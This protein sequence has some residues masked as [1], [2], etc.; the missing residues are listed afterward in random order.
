MNTLDKLGRA[1]RAQPGLREQAVARARQDKALLREVYRKL[2]PAAQTEF[3]KQ[4]GGQM[5]TILD[6]QD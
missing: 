2:P 6:E 4:L 3:R 5:G 1:M